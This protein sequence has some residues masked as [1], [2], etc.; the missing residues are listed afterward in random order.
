MQSDTASVSGST[1]DTDIDV[2]LRTSPPKKTL[3]PARSETDSVNLALGNK[4]TQMG[5]NSP[6]ILD[7]ANVSTPLPSQSFV[8]WIM[9]G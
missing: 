6:V 2:L 8:E 1:P 3:S 5:P 4:F 9:L 7:I